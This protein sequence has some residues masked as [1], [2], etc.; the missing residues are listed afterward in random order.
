MSLALNIHNPGNQL[1]HA[2]SSKIGL[3]MSFNV[4]KERENITIP[5][6]LMLF[7]L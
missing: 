1:L 4:F 3:F 5:S 2:I 6:P 7:V